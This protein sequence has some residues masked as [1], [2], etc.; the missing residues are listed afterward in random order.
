MN[1]FVHYYNNFKRRGIGGSFKYF[2]SYLF[3]P[4]SNR[5]FKYKGENYFY[6]INRY[7]FTWANERSIE[8]PIF[9]KILDEAL[10]KNKSVLEIGCVLNHYFPNQNQ[11][12]VVDKYEK[13]VGVNN[14]DICDFKN[15]K[16][17]TIISISTMEHVGFEEDGDWTKFKKAFENIV[18]NLL[19][20]NGVFIFSIPL[21]YNQKLDEELFSGK[22]K[23]KIDYM[24]RTSTDSWKMVD[25]N[26]AKLAKYNYP[27]ESANA[28]AI[29]YY[30]K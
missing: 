10:F 30:K 12:K 20:K 9:K 6:F 13:F 5:L 23:L 29:C 2:Y 22:Y 16:Y 14:L 27:Y 18:K 11:W 25:K 15:G 28:L 7:S 8:V 26:R 21:G 17:D 19:N 1:R 4:V 24:L 3:L